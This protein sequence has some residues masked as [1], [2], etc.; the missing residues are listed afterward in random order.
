M[1]VESSRS[2]SKEFEK[3]AIFGDV[4]ARRGAELKAG[5]GRWEQGGA[6]GFLKRE[7]EGLKSAGS[8]WM[9]EMWKRPNCLEV[10]SA[11]ETKV[12]GYFDKIRDE[13]Q[14]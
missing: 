10:L 13:A 9:E 1:E 2:R 14:C 12:P 4:K 6:W 11:V 8:F 5:K 7:V 3:L